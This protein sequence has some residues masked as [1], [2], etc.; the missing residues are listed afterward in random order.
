MTG[1]YSDISTF[2]K[3]L[4]LL[5]R[6]CCMRRAERPPPP[7]H[8]LKSRPNRNLF[9]PWHVFLLHQR[10]K[11][12]VCGFLH[13][14]FVDFSNN[15]SKKDPISSASWVAVQCSIMV[16]ILPLGRTYDFSKCRF[17]L[18]HCGAKESNSGNECGRGSEESM[19]K[20]SIR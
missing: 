15:N 8:A 2:S 5:H 9:F 18:Q 17:L 6:I 1:L 7:P 20:N 4:D 11:R 12:N 10:P 16:V 3:S 13:F 19:L 14:S